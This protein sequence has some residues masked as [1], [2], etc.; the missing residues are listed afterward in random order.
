[1]IGVNLLDRLSEVSLECEQV[2]KSIVI[3]SQDLSPELLVLSV[4]PQVETYLD[5][6]ISELLDD[7]AAR[8]DQLGVFL[9]KR[10]GTEYEKTWRNRR[11]IMDKAFAME[12][13]NTP[14]SEQFQLLLEL[15]NALMH[16]AGKFTSRQRSNWT[17]HLKLQSDL[18]KSLNLQIEGNRFYI[19]EDSSDTIRSIATNYLLLTEQGFSGLVHN[20]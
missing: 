12:V 3:S 4:V 16:G 1:M 20:D 8:T 19:P 13:S 11:D 7:Y 5:M 6:R 17:Q 15:R 2:I 10:Y 9:L 18:H 14:E